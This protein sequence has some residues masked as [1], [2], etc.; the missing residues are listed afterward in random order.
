[1]ESH[2][3]F[4]HS[5]RSTHFDRWQA[6]WWNDIIRD[7]CDPEC[8]QIYIRACTGAGKSTLLEALMAWIVAQEPGPTLSITQTDQTSAEWFATRLLPVLRACKPLDSLW[9]TNRHAI[10]KA[11]CNFPHM[12]LLLG[13]ANVSNAQEKSVQHLF[14]DECWTYSDL[15]QQFKRRLH[16]RWNGKTV[17]VTQAHE[18]PH[19]LDAEWTAGRQWE[20]VHDCPGCRKMV[21]PSWLDIKY[22]DAKRED[23]T[24]HWAGVVASV[25][26]ECPHCGHRTDDTTAARRALSMASYWHAEGGQEYI[27]GHVSRW[28]PAFSV[29]WI[30]WSDL[31]LQWLMAHESKQNHQL[32]PLKDFR[33][34]R[35]AQVWTDEL[36]LP[37]VTL[38]AANYE[39]HHYAKGEKIDGEA[40][41]MMTIDVQKDH[42]WIVV[43][44]W[45]SDGTSRLIWCGKLHSTEELKMLQTKLQVAHNRVFLDAGGIYNSR[46][47]DYCARNRWLALMGSQYDS[48][49]IKGVR[50][51]YADWEPQAA[52]T[53]RNHLGKPVDVMRM[54]WASDSIKDI[55]ANLRNIGAPTWEFPK[56]A[57]EYMRHLNSER[58]IQTVDA[59]TKKTRTRWRQIGSRPNHMWDCEAMQVAVAIRMRLIPEVTTLADIADE[60]EAEKQTPSGG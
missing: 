47:L 3:R 45:R 7:F 43:R 34:Q 20:W 60:V 26:H 44:A 36:D 53:V 18:S 41:R 28:I 13:G 4:P 42:F 50:C 5:A 54:M 10:Q 6:P 52:P 17:L 49:K 51:L 9:P 27:A 8:R 30:K 15:I 39:L 16:D 2:V 56:D 14:L 58:K 40:A 48:F 31:V 19:A 24:W 33:L 55:L 37:V 32:Q 57:T 22:D 25:R 12:A 23:G 38:E 21:R 35:L 1:M 29:W 46:V 11:M 59:A